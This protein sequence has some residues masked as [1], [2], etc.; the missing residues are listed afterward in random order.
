[1]GSKG[2]LI[3]D[4]GVC[5][6]GTGRV[7]SRPEGYD[8]GSGRLC[9]DRDEVDDA[10][11]GAMSLMPLWP[12]DVEKL[13]DVEKVDATERRDRNE[14]LPDDVKDEAKD[15]AVELRPVIREPMCRRRSS[16]TYANRWL[17]RTSSESSAEDV[18]S[19]APRCVASTLLGCRGG[20]PS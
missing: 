10:I 13:V 1:L 2:L 18:C 11:D 15:E 9:L 14:E 16:P 12:V 6:A 17:E 5:E 8:R 3:S 20:P 4:V 19:A 7:G